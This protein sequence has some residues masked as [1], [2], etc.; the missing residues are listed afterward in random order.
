MLAERS[1]YYPKP[2]CHGELVKV[3]KAGGQRFPPPHDFR[4][5]SRVIG[6]SP[7]I[8]LEIE[9]ESLAEREK[10]WSD[11]GATPGATAEFR[12]EWTPLASQPY[13]NEIWDMIE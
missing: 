3:L 11:W 4:L 8:A 1:L 5:Y 7:T 9:F 2:G 10:H 12:N 6:T 13:T